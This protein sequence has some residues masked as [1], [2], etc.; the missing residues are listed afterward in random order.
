M[1]GSE[2][3][4][5][6]LCVIGAGSAG[7]SAAAAAA[8]L[9]ASVILIERAR[10]G[11]DCLNVGCVPS[12]A[13][14]AA[15][16]RAH[17][18]ASSSPLG[19]SAGAVS[20]DFPAVMAHVRRTIAAIAPTDSEARY[21]AMGVRVIRASA[22]FVDA[23]TVEA[24]GLTIRAR[25]FILATGSKPTIPPIPG[26]GGVAYLTNETIFD[27]DALPQRLL[28]LGA[29]SIGLEL[30]QAFRRLGS[31]VTV[32]DAGEPLARED[33]EL[34]ALVLD[35]LAA[36]GVVLHTRTRTA[37]VTARGADIILTVDHGAGS[38]E[39]AGSHLLVATGRTPAL[40]GIGLDAAQVERDQDG[41]LRLSKA[42][43]TTNRRIYAA[44]DAAGGGFTHVAGHQ[45]GLV[46]R[47]TL[48]GLPAAFAPADMP[49]VTFTDPELAAVGLSEEEAR[50]KHGRAC[51]Y[52]W[53]FHEN[54]RARA[55]GRTA[56]HLKVVADR[57]GRTLGAAIVG[58]GAGEA[59]HLWAA[60][61][62]QRWTLTKMA[63]LTLP[64]PT[65]GEVS[66]RA[67]LLHVGDR[68]TNPWVGRIIRFVR[69]LP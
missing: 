55:E 62:Q 36:D 42:L 1:T 7:L 2:P 44:G 69:R 19:V 63:S 14:I 47:S 39:I 49:R 29:G 15:A 38:R 68:L 32:V 46:V 40:D 67:A 18:A 4:A 43:R 58:A 28:V 56:G 27:L 25:R 6:D 59:I 13:L 3:L 17:D 21:A 37:S 12:K 33:P 50:Q 54:D 31:E 16:R 61:V 24:G 30:A 57:N 34:V 8:S 53:P 10:M 20:I 9:G 5:P 23:R 35:S 51:V 65:L 45:A 11:G 48:F 26:L 22:R 41:G 60:A 52:R 64:Y 66:R